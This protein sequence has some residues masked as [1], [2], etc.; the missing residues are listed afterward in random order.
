VVDDNIDAGQSLAMLLRQLG[1]DVQVAHDGNAALE[2]VRMNRPQLARVRF[3]AVTGSEGD[4]ARSARA[5]VGFENVTPA[6]SRDD[7][8]HMFG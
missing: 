3:V 7:G 6:L 5:P 1:H 4:E 2:A 8:N